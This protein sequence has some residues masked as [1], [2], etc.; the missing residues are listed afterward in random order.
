MCDKY[1][2]YVCP[3][4]YIKILMQSYVYLCMYV[5]RLWRYTSENASFKL[6]YSQTCTFIN[7]QSLLKIDL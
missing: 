1:I 6:K 3:Y 5:K 7:V 2:I 4:K